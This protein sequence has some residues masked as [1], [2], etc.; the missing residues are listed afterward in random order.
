[1]AE[2]LQPDP[3]RLS[4][5]APS[6]ERS[7]QALPESREHKSRLG[8]TR[9]QQPPRRAKYSFTNVASG[10]HALTITSPTGFALAAGEPSTKSTSVLANQTATVNWGA[11]L[12]AAT[13]SAA[14]DR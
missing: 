10:T 1:V 13:T 7:P 2:G 11:G 6:A 3:A 8:A 4:R 9:P 14:K 5:Q 12:I